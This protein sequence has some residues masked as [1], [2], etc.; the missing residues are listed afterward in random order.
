MR[1]QILDIDPITALR[2]GAKGENLLE[3]LFEFSPESMERIT[4]F[5]EAIE[6]EKRNK[7]KAGGFEFALRKQIRYTFRGSRF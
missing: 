4:P 1:H 3:K 7:C 5:R 6:E 2:G